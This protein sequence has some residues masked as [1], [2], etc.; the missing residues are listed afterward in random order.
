MKMKVAVLGTGFGAYHVGLLKEIGTIDSICIFG[1]NPEKLSA[2]KAKYGVEITT[3]IDQILNDRDIELVDICLPGN[4]HRDYLL[5]CLEKGKHAFCETPFALTRDDASRMVDAARKY[6]KKVCVDTFMKFAAPYQY[7][8]EIQKSQRYGQLKSLRIYRKTPS[9]WGDLGFEHITTDLMIHDLDVVTGLCGKPIRIETFGVT[10]NPGQSE[11]TG[12]LVYDGCQVQVTGNSMMPVTSPFSVGYEAIFEKA[13]VHYYEDS[14]KD[15]V[16]KLIEIFTPEGIDKVEIP[17][18]NYVKNALRHMVDCVVNNE[19]PLNSIES[20]NVSLQLSFDMKDRI[21]QS[22]D[23]A[24]TGR[25]F[26][27][28]VESLL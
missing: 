10:G 2:L 24:V 1:R 26:L 6:G 19:E 11:V 5:Q 28:A 3:N 20:A 15:R 27:Q 23:K 25:D 9:I 16:V 4:L 14:Y 22:V 12:I 7:L 21:M 18:E 17:E 8:Y 13:A